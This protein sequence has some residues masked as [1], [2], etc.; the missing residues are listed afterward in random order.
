MANLVYNNFK[1]KLLDNTLNLSSGSTMSFKLAL[2]TSGYVANQ[3]TDE[4][5]SSVTNESTGAGYSA[6]GST[7]GGIAVAQDDSNNIATWDANDV[8]FAASSITARYGIVYRFATTDVDS[9]LICQ[10]DFS[11]NKTSSSGNFTV[12]W[13]TNGILNLS[14]T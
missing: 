8:T 4:F 9:D 13:S 11:E 1:Q 6:G 3:D 12:A 10:I 14:D 2:T 7:L 5:F